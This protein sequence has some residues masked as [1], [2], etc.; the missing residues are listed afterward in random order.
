MKREEV[1]VSKEEMNTQQEFSE[2]VRE[3]YLLQGKKPKAL[4]ETYGCQQNE[5]DSER[6]R[7][8]LHAMGFSFTEEREE[9]DLI[10]FN[11]CA[12]REGAEMR[13]LGNIGALK[14]LKNRKPE[15]LIGICGC[16]MQQEHMVKKLKSKYKHVSLV[17]GTHSLYM[18]PEILYK[19]VSKQERVIS[20]VESEGRISEDIPVY[21]EKTASA[22]VSIMYGCNNFCSYCIV[23]YV[24]G[25]ERSREPEN[26]LEEI[27]QLVKDGVK[28][29]TLLGQNVNSY[30]KDLP[31][32]MDFA[33]LLLM[34]NEIEGIKRIRFMTSHPKDITDKLIDTLPK[35]TKLCKQM[36]LP[37]QAGSN[38]ILEEMNRKYTKE[39]YLE[40]V[41]KV[42]AV[43]PDAVFTTDIIVG[44]PGETAEDFE[45]TLDVL[46]R[47]RFDSVFSFIYSKREG[48]PAAKMENQVPEDIKHKHFDRL[49]DVQNRISRE[50]N[51]T[52]ADKTE[53]IMVEG[54][55][56]TN[57][58]MMCGR[59]SG[60]KI[61]NFPRDD[62]LKNGDFIQVKI[63]KIST[64]SLAGER[65]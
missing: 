27:R 21:R 2:K 1:I 14:H 3:I 18:F 20:L 40:L 22:W 15:L 25:R 5:H 39:R 36:H 11:T 54:L 42:R 10:L 59:T 6:L 41:D 45:E 48:T 9:A 43:M 32:P 58:E 61:V 8:M 34:V 12:V 50:I 56:K 47:V 30:G 52:Y 51:E 57:E 62:S 64:W 13:V 63:T 24:R 23:P 49:L 65:I 37:F 19:A 55:S 17:F 44:F 35:I 28:E 7:G 38:R 16:M 53:E 33:D 31:E 4:I 29:I 46:E 60:G 26:I